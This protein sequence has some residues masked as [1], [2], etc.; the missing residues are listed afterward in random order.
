MEA[1]ELLNSIK[2]YGKIEYEDE[3]ELLLS[4]I[5]AAMDT[6]EAAGVS[7][8]NPT[9]LYKL[10]VERLALHYYENR[11]EVGNGHPMPMGMNWMVEHLRLN[12]AWWNI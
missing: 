10:A 8:D 11:E 7:K 1:V 12:T 2:M 9:D 3:D 6:L 4:L 5:R